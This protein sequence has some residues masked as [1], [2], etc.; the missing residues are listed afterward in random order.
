MKNSNLSTHSPKGRLIE[1]DGVQYQ[2]INKR[3]CRYADLTMDKGFKIVLGRTGSEEVLRLLLNRLLG[4][5]ISRLEYRNT[6]HPGITEEDRASRFDLYCEDY[7]GKCFQVEMQNW[8]QKYFHKRAV[9][10]S[11][12]IMQ[13]QAAQ[14]I[15]NASYDTDGTKR[16]WDYDFQP[17]YVVSFMNFKNWTSENVG[18]K[19]NE[20]ISLY[21]YS[22][23]ET[24]AELGDGTNLV[25]INLHGFN[26]SLQ[27]CKT[28]EDYWLYSIKN[29]FSMTSCPDEIR[30]TEIESLFIQSEL[31]K[32]TVEQ[33]TKYEEGIM[34][35][36]DILNSIAEQVEEARI[37]AIQ[38]GRE[39]GLRIGMAE[40]IAEG[41]EKGMAEGMVKGMAEGMEK[42]MAEGM[43]K[44]MAEG[45]EKGMAEGKAEGQAEILRKMHAKGMSV[46][47][48]AEILDISPQDVSNILR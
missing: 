5:S 46:Q 6:E 28:L 32:M 45:M 17:F 47:D 30:G 18:N 43:E 44:G 19:R 34:T 38:E 40:G 39:E 1:I 14:A 29:M 12:L 35:Q 9:Y 10:Y 4:I 26:K 20:Y 41:M 48:I 22:D 8:S 13:D 33:R 27:D 21:R 24:N 16:K 3:L 37:S 25:F 23:K 31:A 42:G 7:D 11:S 36:N 15:R 2:V